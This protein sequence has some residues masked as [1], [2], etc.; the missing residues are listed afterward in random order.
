[1]FFTFQLLQTKLNLLSKVNFELMRSFKLINTFTGHA[2]ILWSIDY[3]TFDNCQFICSGS[4]DKTVRVCD[5]DNNEQIQ[6][7][8]GHLST[9]LQIFN[10]HNSKANGI[11]FSPL[12]GAICLCSGSGDKTICLLDV[13][14]SKSLHVS[15]G[16]NMVFGVLIFHHYKT[17]TKMI[18]NKMNNICVIDGNGYTIYWI[19]TIKY[20][21][22]E[23][24]NT[25]LSRSSDESIRLWDIRSD[26]QIQVFNR[27]TSYVLFV[28]YS[29]FVIN[30]SSVNSNV[31]CSGSSDNTIRFWDIRLN[32]SELYMIKGDQKEDNGIYCLKFIVLKKKDDTK[33]AKYDLNLCYGSGKGPICIW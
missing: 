13:E 15:N 2:N 19:V 20:G 23:L 26:Q 11:E 18:I 10:E 17:I 12:N 9:Q 32:K 7:F 4:N 22:N 27:H 28:E 21:S 29:Q 5:V 1:N 33:N 31:I 14:T 8:N 3:A 24:L 16:H 6:L 30:D 25:I